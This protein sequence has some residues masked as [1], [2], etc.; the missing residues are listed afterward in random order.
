MRILRRKESPSQMH[1]LPHRLER[2][3]LLTT[4][5]NYG[6]QSSP[7]FI[8]SVAKGIT[9]SAIFERSSSF[10]QENI[11]RGALELADGISMSHLRT[12][13]MQINLSLLLRKKDFM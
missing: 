2:L 8:M 7:M 9:R 1:H 3:I 11:E 4:K 5:T 13:L 12:N 10:Y 6:L